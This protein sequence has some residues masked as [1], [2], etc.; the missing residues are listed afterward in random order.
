MT[1]SVEQERGRHQRHYSHVEDPE[2][3]HVDVAEPRRSHETDDSGRRSSGAVFMAEA[4]TFERPRTKVLQMVDT[5]ESRSQSNS[6]T[7]GQEEERSER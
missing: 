4:V 7:R 2:R 1:G 3:L 6:P 5:I